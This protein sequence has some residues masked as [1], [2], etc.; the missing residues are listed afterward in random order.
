MKNIVNGLPG[1]STP[2][3]SNLDEPL[4]FFNGD[5]PLTLREACEGFT[6]LGGT[7]SGKTSGPF[8]ACA[9][10]AALPH[11]FGILALAA[12]PDEREFWLKLCRDAGRLQD[13]VIFA[14]DQPATQPADAAPISLANS[15]VDEI[16]LAFHLEETEIAES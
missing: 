14:P 7:G 13:V 12:K 4:L 3:T 11:G 1:G 8:R 5:N 6:I 2:F 15:S 16:P 10:E 9:A